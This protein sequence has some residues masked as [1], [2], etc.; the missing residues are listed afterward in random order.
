[1]KKLIKNK[2]EWADFYYNSDLRV[3]DES[4]SDSPREFPYLIIYNRC[5]NS[6]TE[7]YKIEHIICLS[8]FNV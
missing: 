8:D 4:Y 2:E 3:D 7:C 5:C 6:Y 1:M